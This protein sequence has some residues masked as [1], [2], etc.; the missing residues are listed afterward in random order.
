[1]QGARSGTPATGSIEEPRA[2][3][4]DSEF[5]V[6]DSL[7][8]LEVA[9]GNCFFFKSNLGLG[10]ALAAAWYGAAG[11]L[12]LCCARGDALGAV[13][14]LLMIRFRASFSLLKTRVVCK[15]SCVF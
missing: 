15:S 12:V 10:F 2:R 3:E 8:N 11:K 13:Q 4:L 1:M 7:A 6:L 5:G 9:N 14:L